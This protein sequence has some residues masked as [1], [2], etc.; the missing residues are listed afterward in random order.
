VATQ[1]LIA[2]GGVLFGV[3]LITALLARSEG[4]RRG[5]RLL[6]ASL[7]CMLSYLVALV[8]I[9]QDWLPGNPVVWILACGVALSPALVLGYVRALI[10]PGFALVPR[11]LLHL[12]PALC[13]LL[14]IWVGS[15]DGSESSKEALARARGGWPPSATSIA[16]IVMYLIQIAY[17][18]RALYELYLHRARV[19]TEFSYEE[20]VTLRW[21][22]VLLGISL[23]L[24]SAGLLIALVRLVPGV[25]LWPRSV[26]SMTVVLAVYYLIG[27]MAMSQPAIFAPDSGGEAA[28]AAGDGE[29]SQGAGEEEPKYQTSALTAELAIHYWAELQALMERERPFLDNNLRIADLAAGMDIPV[30]HLSQ[31]INQH[32]GRSFFEFINS[33][34]VA[35]AMELLD[36]ARKSIATIA[37]DAGFNSESAFYRHFKKISGMTPK[38]YQRR[39]APGLAS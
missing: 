16:G 8:L 33:Y 7:A 35:F 15:L 11:D 10:R 22:R 34:R 18:S 36:E 3:M 26:Y 20:H 9:G 32:A 29:V 14:I 23:L 17:Y 39:P 19:A 31:T 21:L 12:L 4:V 5:N 13:C 37:F 25:E 38:Q 30:H 6:A 24:S 1:T 27:F 2:A 28:V